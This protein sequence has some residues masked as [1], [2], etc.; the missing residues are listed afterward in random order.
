MTEHG[1]EDRTRRRGGVLLGCVIVITVILA[2]S[3]LRAT[4]VVMIPIVFSVFLALLVAPVDRWGRRHAPERAAWLGHAAAMGVILLVL[5]AF[6]GSIWIAAQQLME[7]L[8]DNMGVESAAIPLAGPAD[9]SETVPP[10]AS[11]G[12]GQAEEAGE[13]AGIADRLGTLFSSA[14]DSFLGR[15]VDWAAGYAS[16]ILA[17]A[18]TVLGGAVLVFFLTLLMLIEGPAWRDK[19]RALR[20]GPSE[21]VVTD[22]ADEIAE[23]LRRYL[24]TRT[25]IGVL[26]ALLYVGWLWLF[27]IDLLFVWG[28]LAFVLNYIPTLGSLIAGLAPIAYALLTRDLGTAALAAAGVLAIEQVMGNYVDPRM[29]GRQISISPLVVLIVLLFWGWIWGIAGAVLAV[30][31]TIALLILSSHVPPLRPLAVILRDEAEEG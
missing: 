29:Q 15:L 24:W 19:M 14:G 8:P 2:G 22:A 26:T 28:L 11:D 12:S 1:S 10:N 4:A 21:G 25:V 16:T 17:T 6:V 30:P 18:G 9:P 31:I 7:R 20:R 3:M 5:L 23:K 13:E 27:G